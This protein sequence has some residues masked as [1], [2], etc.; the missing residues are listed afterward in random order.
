MSELG[1]AIRTRRR[2]LGISARDL[3]SRIGV[4][5]T[6]IWNVESSKINPPT[7]RTLS[8]I[9]EVLLIDEDVLTSLASRVHVV[10]KSGYGQVALF[11]KCSAI[12]RDTEDELLLW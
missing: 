6:Y 11:D 5:E 10:R 12:R 7:Q 8:H 4:N 9:A 1:T 3:A 2:D